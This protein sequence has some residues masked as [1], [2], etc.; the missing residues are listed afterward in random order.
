MIDLFELV[1]VVSCT[2]Q[3]GYV[4]GVATLWPV[5]DKFTVGKHIF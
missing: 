5:F 4:K 3:I 2:Q 1:R